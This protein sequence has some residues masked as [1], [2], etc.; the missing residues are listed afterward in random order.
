MRQE[1]KDTIVIVLAALLL[2][3]A[4]F[5]TGQY[6]GKRKAREEIKPQIDTIILRDTISLEKP[7]YISS[8]VVDTMLVPVTDT[9][10]VHDTLMVQ[11]PREEKVYQDSL[12]RAV[13]SG[14]RPSLDSISIYQQTKI[15]NKTIV[16]PQYRRW[17]LGVQIGVGMGDQLQ[18]TPYI[19]V[20]LSYNLLCF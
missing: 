17:G 6:R 13:V 1:I 14:F 10:M 16:L 3:V 20:G 11:I 9:L 4:C 8:R 2:G 15:I 19:G 5:F 7:I 12:Y 18:L